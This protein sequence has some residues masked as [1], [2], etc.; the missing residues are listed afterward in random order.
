MDSED[1]DPYLTFMLEHRIV[2]CHVE[3]SVSPILCLAGTLPAG[4]LS[5]TFNITNVELLRPDNGA[6]F[7]SAIRG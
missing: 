4:L 6:T 3:L 7:P 1:I 5:G 2:Q